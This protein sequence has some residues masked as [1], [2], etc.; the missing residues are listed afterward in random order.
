M[1]DDIHDSPTPPTATPRASI[2]KPKAKAKAKPKAAGRKCVTH[3][4]DGA[5]EV[6]LPAATDAPKPAK[7]VK[8]ADRNVRAA[9]PKS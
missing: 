2:P 6:E 5:V 7:K 4:K 9:K 8:T 1:A 3:T